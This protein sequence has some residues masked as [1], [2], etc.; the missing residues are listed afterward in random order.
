KHTKKKQK[1]DCITRYTPKIIIIIENIDL[2]TALCK[3]SNY[4]FWNPKAIRS[5]GRKLESCSLQQLLVRGN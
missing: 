5:E 4:H 2:T 3:P 1:I